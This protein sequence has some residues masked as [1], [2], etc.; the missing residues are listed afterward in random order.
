MFRTFCRGSSFLRVL[1][2]GLDYKVY[3]FVYL[4]VFR[5]NDML[6]LGVVF[7]GLFL[8]RFRGGGKWFLLVFCIVRYR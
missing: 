1:F 5:V 8:G 7:R 3:L 6:G 4:F 2:L